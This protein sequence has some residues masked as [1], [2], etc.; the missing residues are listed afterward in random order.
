MPA[1]SVRAIGYGA[2]TR[3]FDRTPNVLRVV[4]GER[5][6]V[7]VQ[8]RSDGQA[9]VK[10]ECE[11]DDMSPQLFGPVSEQLLAAG[12]LDVFLTAVQMKKGRPGT[13]AHRACAARA[14]A[15]RSAMCCSARRRRSVCGSSGC[16]ARRS[17][18]AGSTSRRRRLGADQGRRPP[19]RGAQRG[20]G[21]RRLRARRR[22]R[23]AGRS[24]T[25]RRRRC[26]PGRTQVMK[27]G[28]VRRRDRA[29]RRAITRRPAPD[30]C[31]STG[32]FSMNDLSA[33]R[34]FTS[35]PP[36]TTSTA[37][38]TSARPTR[39]SRPTSSRAT[40][41]SRGSTCG[42]SWATTSTRRTSFARR[43][44][45]GL[46]AA[47]LL[48]P[49]GARVPRRSGRASTS[50]STTSSGRPS[51]GTRPRVAGAGPALVSTPATSTRATTRAGTAS[52]CEAFKQE[53]DLVDGLCPI[54][55]T[56]P[57]WI[58]EKNYFFRLSTYRDRAARALRGA[59]GVR[60]ARVAAQ[61]DAAAARRRPRG[62]LGQPRRTVVGHSAAVRSDERRLRL[63]RRAHQ[64]RRGRR[65]TARDK[66]LFDTWWPADLHV[67]GKDITRF[68]CVVWPAMLMSAGVALP[69]QVFGHGWV[70]FKGEKMSKSLGHRRRSARGGRAARPGSAA[71]V[72]DEGDR[73][74]SGRRLLVGAV[75]EV[76]QRRPREQPRQP[77]QPRDVDGATG[78]A[79]AC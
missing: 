72:S 10:I 48:R 47:G 59:S 1:M 29:A 79:G 4:I 31:S 25:C 65:A 73:L 14:C 42:S 5:V 57:D 63:V 76:L 13:L 32:S 69:R 39:R 38:R 78:I 16:G 6:D 37:A 43:A 51:R 2:G 54:H 3:D 66:A 70:L 45:L 27:S 22:P 34:A 40:S 23:R 64:L 53:K 11:I 56:K 52:S 49:D 67:V 24:R 9:V 28:E 58:K 61:R 21:V 19:R 44:E 62:H 60:R 71:A 50:R 41:G 15:K 18:A 68:H 33:C 36:S 55:Q 77:R 26:A 35:P 30:L 46:D 7:D 17:S 8:P 12:A 20:A 75:R 74:R